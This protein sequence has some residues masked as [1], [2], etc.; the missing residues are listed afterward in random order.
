MAAER[1]YTGVTPQAEECLRTNLA[2]EGIH[3]PEGNT[4]EITYAKYDIKIKFVWDGKEKLDLTLEKKAWYVPT[5]KVWDV[6]DA[7]V[8]HCGGKVV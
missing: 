6:T 1:H 4:G 7:G 8:E 5:S 3:L 2:K